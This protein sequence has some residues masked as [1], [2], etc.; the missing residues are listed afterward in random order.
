MGLAQWPGVRDVSKQNTHTHTE[1]IT[2]RHTL[3]LE[4]KLVNIAVE[5]KYLLFKKRKSNKT[6]KKYLKQNNAAKQ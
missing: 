1:K 3:T 5:W 4:K 6:Q 2:N